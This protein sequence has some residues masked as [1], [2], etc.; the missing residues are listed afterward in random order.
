MSDP[1]RHRA[2][3]LAAEFLSRGDGVGWFEP[4]YA[5]A[6]KN[7]SRIPWADQHPNPNLLDWLQREGLLATGKSA[8]VVG[9]GLGD[10]AEHLAHRGFR[11]TAFDISASAIEW[12]RERF[13]ESHVCYEVRNVLQLPGSWKQ[14]FDFVFEAYTLQVLPPELRPPAIGQIASALKPQG[15]LLVICRG[16]NPEDPQ[17]QMPWPLLREELLGFDEYGLRETAFEDYLDQS[18]DPPVRRLRATYTRPA[19]SECP[20]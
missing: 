15:T 14:A 16:R 12:C 17:G 20:P 1:Q 6:G 9:C 11:V 18:E 13:P 8:L 4:L 5:E 7:P 3:E 19:S 10:D 2:R